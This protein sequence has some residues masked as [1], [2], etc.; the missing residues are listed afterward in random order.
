MVLLIISGLIIEKPLRGYFK[1][2]EYFYEKPMNFFW[3]HWKALKTLTLDTVWVFTENSCN[4]E[5]LVQEKL[6]NWGYW[7]IDFWLGRERILE[8][9]DYLFMIFMFSCHCR[10]LINH[11]FWIITQSLRAPPPP[12]L[13]SSSLANFLNLSHILHFI[14]S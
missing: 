14:V 12:P 11:I 8:D 10:Y 7:H 5:P 4:H 1:R 13:N 2:S 3:M 9:K 6:L